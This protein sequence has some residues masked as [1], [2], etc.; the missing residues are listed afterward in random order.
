MS[1]YLIRFKGVLLLESIQHLLKLSMNKH[2][3]PIGEELGIQE[4]CYMNFNQVDDQE[5]IGIMNDC[6][7]IG[8]D[9]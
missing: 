1:K 6:F 3:H 4:K 7:R 2:E 9:S 5:I 8:L